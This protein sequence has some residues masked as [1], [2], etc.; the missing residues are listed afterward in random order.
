MPPD[1]AR[2]T[3]SMPSPPTEP[4]QGRNDLLANLDRHA[5]G[6]RIASQSIGDAVV[7]IDP[8]ARVHSLNAR[9]E[10]L[11]GWSADEARGRPVSEVFRVVSAATGDPAS[12]RVA[13]CMMVGRVEPRTGAVVLLRRDGGA[14]PIQDCATS[15][16][17]AEGTLC[18][19][20]L[21][22]DEVQHARPRPSD[23]FDAAGRASGAAPLHDAPAAARPPAAGVPAPTEDLA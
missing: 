7:T 17:D 12:D 21:V 3:L 13:Q 5:E 19:V 20:V 14:V 9:A 23:A 10:A 15:V 11:T 16:S 2:S 1:L 8:C 4:A 22:F 18:G 6:M